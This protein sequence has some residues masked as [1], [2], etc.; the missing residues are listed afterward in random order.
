MLQRFDDWPTRLDRFLD[1]R[2]LESFSWGK[3]D[4]CL[5]ACDAVLAMTGTD[6]AADFRGQYHDARSALEFLGGRELGDFAAENLANQGVTEL[7]APQRWARRGD[8][9]LAEYQGQEALG[10]VGLSGDEAWAPG[11][12][13]LQKVP[14][15]M[16]LRAWRI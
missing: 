9:V 2:K 8:M 10:V 16:V 14:M 15:E 1:S 12:F 7:A 13:V 6:L 3:H 5:F 4:C 11:E